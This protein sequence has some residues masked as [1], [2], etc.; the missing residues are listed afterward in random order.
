MTKRSIMRD[1]DSRTQ[2]QRVSH[3]IEFISHGEHFSIKKERVRDVMLIRVYS[4][5]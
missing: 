1:W 5:M 2:I 4:L 3:N